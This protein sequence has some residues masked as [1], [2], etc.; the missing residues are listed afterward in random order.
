MGSILN[1]TTDD[2]HPATTRDGLSL[3]FTRGVV[4]TGTGPDIWVTE[5]S[6]ND[7]SCPW[8]TPYLVSNVNSA[9][10]DAVP[11][12]T[13][14]GHTMYFHSAR[15][16]GCG[17]AADLYMAHRDDVADNRAWGTPVNLGCPPDT[18]RA[19]NGPFFFNNAAAGRQ[20]LYF[21][22]TGSPAI[23]GGLGN[24][25]IL[26]STRVDDTSPWSAGVVVSSLSSAG[27]DDRPTIRQDGLEVIFSSNRLGT[28]GMTDLW[29]A[30]RT[31][32][33][34]DWSNVQNLGA[35]IN[36][37]ANEGGAALSFDAKTLY[38][39]SDRTDGTG[40]GGRDLY[41]STR[42]KWCR[43]SARC[44]DVTVAADNV[45][46]GTASVNAGS[47]D[48]DGDG[49]VS[50]TQSPAGPYALGATQVTLTCTDQASQQTSFCTGTV[51]VADTTPPVV[52]MR[53][54]AGE[55]I[56]SLWPVNGAFHTV[57][58]DD[59]I[60]SA[61]DQCD[62]VDVTREIAGV[63]SDESVNKD[64]DIAIA[65]DGSSAQLRAERNGSG[66]GRVYTV[67]VVVADHSGNATHVSCKVGVPHDQSGSPALDSGAAYCVGTCPMP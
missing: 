35:A 2:F 42:S 16:G 28:A 17:G 62:G 26:L 36:T 57:A 3:Y 45:C 61:L 38:F 29:M 34:D 10:N 7:A 51:T 15:P 41:M 8:T 49:D 14:D 32:T 27:N 46:Q 11:N 67:F 50:C 47:S 48:N 40:F 20:E 54:E 19:E 25:D 66:D 53:P 22:A 56:A 39:Y 60:Q 4:G 1:T 44:Q 6:C 24:S 30:T 21:S 5:R 37:S 65:A 18:G 59:C 12:I 33:L 43:P 58:V 63:S 9:V 23:P 55:L 31:S 13:P 52:T 64:V